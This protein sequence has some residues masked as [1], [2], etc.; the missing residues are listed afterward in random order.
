[1]I[2]RRK[3]EVVP[4]DPQWAAEFKHLSEQLLKLFPDNTIKLYHIGSTSVPGLA[5]KPII[6]ILGEVSDIEL[7]EKITQKLEDSGYIAK[8]EN[9]IAGRRYFFKVQDGQRKCH[10]H[11]YQTGHPDINRH[12]VFRDYLR[13]HPEEA[14]RYG[15]VKAEAAA[16]NTHNI[17]LYIQEKSPII[18]ELEA[19]AI[20]WATRS[21]E[22]TTK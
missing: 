20:K 4:F 7:V 19:S 16:R 6:D 11:I 14:K 10:L 18:K 22:N 1:M 15:D 12:L 3:V 9:G 5:A 21:N 13:A 8:G 17:D 2:E